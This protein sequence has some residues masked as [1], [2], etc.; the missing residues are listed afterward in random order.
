MKLTKIS[1][2]SQKENTLD[3]PTLDETQYEQWVNQPRQTR[4]HIQDAFPQL[5]A[6]EREFILSGLTSE[7]F[8]KLFGDPE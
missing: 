7:E 3:I 8:R 2:S 1:L 4:P 6:D 5:T